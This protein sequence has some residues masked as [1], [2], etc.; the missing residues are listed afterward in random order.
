MIAT[1][2]DQVKTV[3]D[4]N[5]KLVAE[6]KLPSVA[7]VILIYNGAAVIEKCLESVFCS[8]YQGPMEVVVIDNASTD[9]SLEAI[10]RFINTVGG[11]VFDHGKITIKNMPLGYHFLKDNLGWAGGNNYGISRASSDWDLVLF[12]NDDV[13]LGP[14]TIS[15]L[16]KDSI[17]ANQHP[18][19]YYKVGI[20]G[21]K[22]LYPDGTVQHLGA[23]IGP[24]GHTKHYL[25]DCPNAR[26]NNIPHYVTG[27]AIMITRACWEACGKFPECYHMYYEEAEY[28]VRARKRGYETVCVPSAVATHHADQRE[29]RSKYMFYLRYERSRLRFVWRNF[30]C[31]EILGWYN[32]EVYWYKANIKGNHDDHADATRR[33]YAEMLWKLPWIALTRAK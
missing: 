10:N 16:V 21:C 20:F 5:S 9:G 1:H 28:C 32:E 22:L 11:L 12:L 3:L 14:D 23:E 25:A 24:T 17:I 6:R 29:D 30:S 27:A 2:Q 31:R 7:V 4:S 8:D 33:A 15:E 18:I 19:N 13:E 26:N